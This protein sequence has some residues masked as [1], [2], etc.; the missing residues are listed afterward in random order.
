MTKNIKVKLRN[1]IIKYYLS[2]PM[3]IKQVSEEYNLCCPTISKILK[4]IP[5]YPKSQINNPCLE[6]HYFN[7]IDNE[8]KAYFLG[9]LISDGN[10]FKDKTGRQNSIS[11]TLDL[12]DKYLLEKFKECIRT[13]TIIAKDG[14]GCGQIAIRSNIMAKDLEKYGVVPRKSF[15]TY[16]PIISDIYMKDLIRGI[17]DGDGSIISKLNHDN[18]FLHCI[19]F[20]G[21]HKLMEDISSYIYKNLKLNQKP[22]VYDYKDRKLSEIK[23]QNKLDILV[24]GEWIYNDCQI[25]MKRKK[26]IYNDFKKHYNL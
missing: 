7:I 14:R 17:F 20:C 22:K 9:L 1:E 13:N 26:K 25:F 18:R 8:Y 6:E 12:E 5:K 23:I 2:Y 3:T 21:T 19:S 15:K 10:V 4:D 11:I 16:L 24:F